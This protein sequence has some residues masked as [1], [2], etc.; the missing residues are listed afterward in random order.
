VLYYKQY[1]FEEALMVNRILLNGLHYEPNGAGISRYNHKLIDAFI[2]GGYPLDILMRKD[3]VDQ[4]K[5]ANI[6]FVDKDITSSTGRIL[7]EQLRET[8]HYKNYEL[9]HF[10]DYA[11]PPL[12]NGAKVATI[13]DMAMHTMKD[14]Y[15]FM[16]NLTKNILLQYTIR[17]ADRLI[18]DSEFTK[19]E[20]LNYYPKV[21]DKAKV[22]Y[23]GI[24]TPKIDIDE[25]TKG[26]VLSEFNIHSKFILYVGTIAPHKNIHSL[27]KAFANVKKQGY[28]YSLVI[29]G[30]KGW[31]Y[32]EVFHTIRN[33][34]L[35]KDVIFTG[36]IKDL[37][38]E[39]LYKATEFFVSVSLYEGFGFP[40]L[41]A[42]V[43]GCPV[44]VSNIEA[45][46]EMC[47]NHASFCNPKDI[48]DI[49][50]HLL[51]ML[52]NQELRYGL[53]Q[54]GMER[55]KQFNWDKTAKETY[56]VY[57]EVLK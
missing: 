51:E 54:L 47:G 14:K 13:H 30:K 19:K 46:K 43:R 31:M 22:V 52:D 7:Q 57:E 27:I 29:A 40:P 5:S 18:C 10:P 55:A 20:L 17:K 50:K 45:F 2:K 34:G 23:L 4:Y 44:L 33:L 41:E 25:V 9:I 11:T 48:D 26:R 42:M 36:F 6:R 56:E 49:T 21:E 32:E 12:Y 28:E 8:G 53:I 24:E 16:Q 15:T 38:L 1:G 37:E 3:F 35:E 39:V